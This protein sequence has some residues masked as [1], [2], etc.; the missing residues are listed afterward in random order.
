MPELPEVETVRKSLIDLIIG[1]QIENV[2]VRYANIIHTPVFEFISNLKGQTFKDVKRIGKYL[3]FVLD[4]YLLVSHLRMEGKYF[5][6]LKK[7]ELSKHD[8]IIF[9]FTDDTSLRYNDTRKFGTMYLFHTT[10]IDDIRNIHPL[11]NVG[12]EPF[13]ENMN[14]EYLKSKIKKSAK[15]IKTML[16]DQSIMCGLGNIYVDEV[17]FMC[18]FHPQMPC[19][20]LTDDDLKAVIENSKVVLEKAINLGGTTIKSFVNSHAATGLF[21]NELL[22]HTKEECPICH[23]KITKIVVGGRGTYFCEKCQQL[24]DKQHKK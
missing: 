2:E 17:C 15:P 12:L 16:L 7:E 9:N 6:K 14:I 1:K 19:N 11:N 13:D 4:D 24:I 10:N 21:Q 22:V 5:L 18:H 23:T 8:H 3:I 20:T